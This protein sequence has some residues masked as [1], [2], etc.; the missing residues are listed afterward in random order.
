[1]LVTSRC[2]FNR[3][4]A[5]VMGILQILKEKISRKLAQINVIEI[6]SEKINDHLINDLG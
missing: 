4:F 2:Y 5:A 1:M 6:K 3:I